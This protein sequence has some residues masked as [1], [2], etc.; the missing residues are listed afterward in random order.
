MDGYLLA[1]RMGCKGCTVYRDGSSDKQI[2]NIAK[3]P[4]P[5]DPNTGLTDE[6]PMVNTSSVPTEGYQVPKSMGKKKL[7][8]AAFAQVVMGRLLLLKAVILAPTAP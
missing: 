6:M 7:L 5:M 3:D 8:R 1:W 2:L 4:E